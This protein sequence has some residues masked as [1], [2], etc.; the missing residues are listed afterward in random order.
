MLNLNSN[1]EEKI[2]SDRQFLK[3]SAWFQ[4]QGKVYLCEGHVEIDDVLEPVA[5]FF[6]IDY[7]GRSVDLQSMKHPRILNSL[8]GLPDHCFG[9]K[10]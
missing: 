10:G 5:D 4:T 2:W 7:S 3:L 1:K 6:S 8:S 9:R